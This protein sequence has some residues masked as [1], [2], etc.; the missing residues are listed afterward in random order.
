MPP[1]VSGAMFGAIDA[2]EHW[3]MDMVS[4]RGIQKSEVAHLVG[5]G[6]F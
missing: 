5:H 4:L 3:T 6:K 2:K 1:G